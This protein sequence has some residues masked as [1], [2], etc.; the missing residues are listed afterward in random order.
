M[1]ELI[2][3]TCP[4]RN[5]QKRSFSCLV[6]AICYSWSSRFPSILIFSNYFCHIFILFV[7]DIS[8]IKITMKLMLP[9]ILVFF[10]FLV[11]L[12]QYFRKC[13]VSQMSLHLFHAQKRGKNVIESFPA[14]DSSW[15]LSVCC[16]LPFE[17]KFPSL[18]IAKLELAEGKVFYC[19]LGC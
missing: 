6:A 18:A 4:C 10:I 19:L 5:Y 7:Q 11:P 15:I 2:C 3:I 16:T 17:W 14:P 9:N 12:G 1:N 8:E 13:F